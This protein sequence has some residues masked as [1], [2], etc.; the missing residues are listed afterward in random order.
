MPRAMQA[1]RHRPCVWWP[2]WPWPAGRCLPLCAVSGGLAPFCCLRVGAWA[3]VVLGGAPGGLAAVAGLG[4]GLAAPGTHHPPV[5][6][7]VASHGPRVAGP[8]LL[9]PRALPGLPS[10]WLA[11]RRRTH[12]LAVVSI[13]APTLRETLGPQCCGT[14]LL[15]LAGEAGTLGA[16]RG[17]ASVLTPSLVRTPWSGW[18]GQTW[19]A[20]LQPWGGKCCTGTPT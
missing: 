10:V 6:A 9:G 20:T 8:D 5:L 2:W 15:W 18:T 13:T 1:G 12:G 17:T 14:G 4:P 3:A 19:A 11:W 7:V 16:T